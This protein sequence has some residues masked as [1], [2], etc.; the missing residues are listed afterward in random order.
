MLS[1]SLSA[2]GRMAYSCEGAHAVE[3]LT[4]AQYRQRL[5][6]DVAEKVVFDWSTLSRVLSPILSQHGLEA[7]PHQ[8]RSAITVKGERIALGCS[9]N[10]VTGWIFLTAQVQ[11]GTLRLFAEESEDP[12]LLQ[13]LT[14][15]LVGF[16]LPVDVKGI[17]QHARRLLDKTTR[18]SQ[19]QLSRPEL[20]ERLALRAEGL[21]T[22]VST[23]IV[24]EGLALSIH[25]HEPGE[26]P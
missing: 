18:L 4:V 9:G 17:E 20:T 26:K 8:L 7:S 19:I 22:D 12:A 1:T 14:S 2:R 16:T 13:Q 15:L 3:P 25:V 23:Q 6:F 10:Q 11:N 5:P 24:P 21:R